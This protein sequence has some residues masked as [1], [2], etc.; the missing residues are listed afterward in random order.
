MVKRTRDEALETRSALLDT[1]EHVFS[2]H[3]VS[4]T[5]LADIA[6]AAGVTRGAIYWH[7]QDKA[8]LF[9]K[10]VA[11]VTLPMEDAP[12]QA[13]HHESADPLAS[14]RAMMIDILKRTSEDPQ[15]RR[16]FHIAFHKCE[17]VD[18]MEVVWNR[19]KEMRSGCLMRLEQG[20]DA[21]IARGQLPKGLNA[22]HAALGLHAMMDGLIS[23]WVTDPE[24]VPLQR[25]SEQ[26][27]DLFLA[28]LRSVDAAR[29]T[30][31]RTA[32]KSASRTRGRVRKRATAAGNRGGRR[33][34]R[35]GA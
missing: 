15:A 7:F 6:R 2:A 16:V 17:Y 32:P 10:M 9:C 11:R 21:A 24:S 19:F 13:V 25:E 22:R 30:A 28:A 27:V 26:I 4:R 14:I 33:N 18:E 23:R 34:G 20:L 31:G 5:S 29:A 3:G 1:A 12:C 35:R 8:D